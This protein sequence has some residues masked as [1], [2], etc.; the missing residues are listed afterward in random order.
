VARPAALA[1]K[2]GA[3]VIAPKKQKL[4]AQKKLL[5]V[6]VDILLVDM[7]TQVKAKVNCRSTQ[8]GSLLSRRRI[9]QKRQ[10]ILR[11]SLA[12][13]KSTKRRA[14]RRK[15]EVET[16]NSALGKFGGHFCGSSQ[17]E[18]LGSKLPLA[19]TLSRKCP[20]AGTICDLSL[21]CRGRAG[22]RV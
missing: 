20:A 8:L 7:S 5:K 14:L 17:N 1:P 15:N 18:K 9:W 2:R 22:R 13:R 11:C 10:D 16:L 12:A 6:S 21:P 3:R 4:I 19:M